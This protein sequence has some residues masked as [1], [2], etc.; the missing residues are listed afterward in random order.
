MSVCQHYITVDRPTTYRNAL[1]TLFFGAN[2]PLDGRTV[3]PI[4]IILFVMEYFVS[5]VDDAHSAT[6]TR[7]PAPLDRPQQHGKADDG[8]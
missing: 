6:N 3:T 5:G 1:R 2:V 7:R 4:E 8:M